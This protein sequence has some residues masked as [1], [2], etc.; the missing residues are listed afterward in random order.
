MRAALAF[1]AVL[2]LTACAFSSE[3]PLFAGPTATPIADGA[4]VEWR[5]N[6]AVEQTVIYRRV[7]PGYDVAP[8]AREET[9]LHVEFY[10]IASTPEDDYIAQASVE[11]AGEGRFYAFMWR[12]ADGFRVIGGPDGVDNDAVLER[13]CAVRANRECAFT[14]R[15]AVLALY[16]AAIYP[17][18]VRDGETPEDYIDQ[19]PAEAG[20]PETT[21]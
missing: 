19:V 4:R 6:G 3:R 12:T 7:G 18:F 13:H 15:A 8:A 2:A 10:A 1:A 9:P 5:E 21:K 14:S 17:R 11:R 16:R 20:A